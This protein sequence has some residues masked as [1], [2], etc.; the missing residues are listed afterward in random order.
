[1]S[2]NFTNYTGTSDITA[3]LSLPNYV[4]GGWAWMLVIFSIF[5][6]LILTFSRY[7]KEYAMISAGMVCSILTMILSA[8]T[9]GGVPLV[10]PLSVSLYVGV[11]L[12][13]FIVAS[14]TKPY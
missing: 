11:A 13:G 14:F 5:I 10:N 12:V 6:I 8:I 7:R 3:I 2:F 4:T 1:M 9:F